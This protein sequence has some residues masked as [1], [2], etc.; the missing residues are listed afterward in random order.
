M[1]NTRR[2]EITHCWGC[3]TTLRTDFLWF[4]RV[5]LVLPAIRSHSLM[6]ESWLPV[7]LKTLEF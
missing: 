7:K 2:V 5:A 1:T 6:V 4:V 3:S